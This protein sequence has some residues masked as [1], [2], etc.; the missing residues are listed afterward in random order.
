MKR[1]VG[2]GIDFGTTNSSVAIGY[3]D[4]RNA[5]D[6]RQERAVRGFSM[7]GETHSRPY[8]LVP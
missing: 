2:Y 6:S 4:A 3:D 1:A 7:P 5:A 8:R